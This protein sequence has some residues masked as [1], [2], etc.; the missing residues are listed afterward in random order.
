MHIETIVN[1]RLKDVQKNYMSYMYMPILHNYN[2]LAIKNIL[3][4]EKWDIFNV[5]N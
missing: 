5:A 3:N 1:W 4:P 2:E